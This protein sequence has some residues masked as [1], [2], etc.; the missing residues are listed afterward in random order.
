MTTRVSNV[1]HDT[2]HD[3][4]I[5]ELSIESGV[6]SFKMSSSDESL[7]MSYDSYSE[8]YDISKTL[9]SKKEIVMYGIPPD[10]TDEVM[11]RYLNK[12]RIENKVFF[13]K[14]GK[15]LNGLI[16]YAKKTKK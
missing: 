14:K 1:I 10:T 4:L 15:E 6:N 5:R 2:T 16:Y 8:R 12:I 9:T 3:N 13:D 7:D 11:L